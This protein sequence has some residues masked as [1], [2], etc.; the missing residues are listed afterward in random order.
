[1]TTDYTG[2]AN[3]FFARE[4]DP[5]QLAKLFAIFR[6]GEHHAVITIQSRQGGLH[7]RVREED[8]DADI[9]HNV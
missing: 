4:R 6:I 3:K 2:V 5:D 1:M 7:S 9:P 8:S